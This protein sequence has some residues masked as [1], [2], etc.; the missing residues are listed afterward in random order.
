MLS[1]RALEAVQAMMPP[2]LLLC[3]QLPNEPVPSVDLVPAEPPARPPRVWRVM[4]ATAKAQWVQIR[5]FLPRMERTIYFGVF[6]FWNRFNCWPT[7]AELL[8]FLLTLKARHPHHPRYR[9]VVNIN[10]VAPRLSSMSHRLDSKG[11]PKTPLLFISVPR[12]CTSDLARSHQAN[13]SPARTVMTYRI[14]Q[15]GD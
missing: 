11:E 2:L 6:A 12:H 1:R 4:R 13:G 10:N 5:P 14:P 15:V 9:W 8:E 7:A 3:D